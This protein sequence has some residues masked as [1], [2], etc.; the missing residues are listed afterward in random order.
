MGKKIRDK[1]KKEK[2]KRKKIDSTK[3]TQKRKK[4]KP[5]SI[6]N[7]IIKSGTENELEQELEKLNI[8]ILLA[9]FAMGFA[10]VSNVYAVIIICYERYLF[11]S[12]LQH[13]PVI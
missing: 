13:V 8:L 1:K 6:T 2:K 10:F 3:K 9:C 4:I 7:N 11:K 12:N 5:E